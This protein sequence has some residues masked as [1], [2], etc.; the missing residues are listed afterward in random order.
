TLKGYTNWVSAMAFSPDGTTLALASDDGTIKLWDTRSGALQQTLKGHKDRG[1]NA[2]A[3]S[4]DGTTLASVSSDGT[5]ELWDARSGALQ[6]A[7]KGHEDRWARA[8]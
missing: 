4:P 2:V 8:V 7:L 5:I 3:F 6:Q 1:V